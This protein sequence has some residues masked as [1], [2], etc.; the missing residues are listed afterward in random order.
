MRTVYKDW[1]NAVYM[2]ADADEADL[3]MIGI[4]NDLYAES[5]NDSVDYSI[6]VGQDEFDNF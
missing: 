4:V 5:S 2:P 6:I 1:Y 3:L